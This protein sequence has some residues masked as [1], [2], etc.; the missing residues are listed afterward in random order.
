MMEWVV[1]SDI[2]GNYEA[3]RSLLEAEKPNGKRQYL[4]LGDVVGYY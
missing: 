3:L 1:F 4:F 2:H